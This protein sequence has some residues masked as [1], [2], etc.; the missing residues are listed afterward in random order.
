MDRGI[1]GV[2]A[3]RAMKLHKLDALTANFQIRT[4]FQLSNSKS[5]RYRLIAA[6]VCDEYWIGPVH[7]FDQIV[8]DI[9]LQ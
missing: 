8:P 5:S 6:S 2:T 9:F 3:R 1:F 4:R 7:L